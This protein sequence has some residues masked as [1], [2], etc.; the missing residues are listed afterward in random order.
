MRTTPLLAVLLLS[1]CANAQET[2]R[3]IREGNAAY[4]QGDQNAAIRS[5][6]KARAD[7]RGAF[8]LGNAHY[9]QDSLADAQRDFEAASTLAKTPAEQARAFHNLGNSRMGQQQWQEAVDA[10]KQALK[11]A[12]GDEDTRYN[13]AYAQK[14]LQEEQK[15][16]DQQQGG[17]N[18]QQQDQQQQQKQD[19][20][21]KQQQPEQ[22][23]QAK[24]QQQQK[25][26]QFS[27]QDAERMLEAMQQQEKSAQ[28][29]ARENMRVRARVP[30]EKDW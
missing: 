22:D 7:Q 18:K 27:K 14:K 28:N 30:I 21:A 17:D 25:P 5:Y 19:Q 16:K 9:R 6:S 3:A 29:K 23:Q 2:D 20:Q 1:L 15:K 11:R 24:E 4:K 10:Y 26:G 12:P 8:N 13:L